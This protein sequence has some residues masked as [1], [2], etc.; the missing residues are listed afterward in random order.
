MNPPQIFVLPY[1]Q[2]IN[3]KAYWAITDYGKTVFIY[4]RR[5]TMSFASKSK[6]QLQTDI[7]RVLLN[8]YLSVHNEINNSTNCIDKLMRE[9]NE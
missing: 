4:Y 6:S 9:T 5:L 7:Q 3:V 2:L 8:P 1:L